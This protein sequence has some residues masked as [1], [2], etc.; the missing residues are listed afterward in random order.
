MYDWSDEGEVEVVVEDIERID[1]NK[2]EPHDKKMSDWVF[3]LEEDYAVM[4]RQWV[5]RNLIWFYMFW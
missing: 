5:P 4:R 3:H 1:F 2:Y